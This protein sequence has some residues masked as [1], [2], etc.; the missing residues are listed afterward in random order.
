MTAARTVWFSFRLGCHRSAVLLS[1]LNVSPLT[2][3]IAPVWS[4]DPCYSSPPHQGRSSPTNTPVFPPSSFILPS[5]P[6]FHIFF[7]SGQALLSALSWCSA[8]TSV[9]EDVSLMDPWRGMSST[10]SYSS[11]ILFSC[12]QVVLDWVFI[13]TNQLQDIWGRYKREEFKRVLVITWY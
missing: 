13:S 10:S 1:A 7:S 6:W 2:Q 11:A 12:L 5:L 4:W 8:C 9:P 3:I